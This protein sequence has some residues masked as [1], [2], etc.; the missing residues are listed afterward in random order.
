ME[1]SLGKKQRIDGSDSTEFSERRVIVKNGSTNT[2]TLL[3]FWL[4][5]SIVILEARKELVWIVFE[6]NSHLAQ[7]EES[8]FFCSSLQSSVIPST[9]QILGSKCFLY[10]KSL[11][12]VSFESNSHL[13]RIESKAFLCSS[14]QSILIPR[15]V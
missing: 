6:F 5:N 14:L 8:T 9:V 15:N 1:S 4:P 11:S 3:R 13:A 12:S 7:I 10:C 2:V